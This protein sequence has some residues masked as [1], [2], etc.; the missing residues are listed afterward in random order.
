MAQAAANA[1]KPA[2]ARPREAPAESSRYT[3]LQSSAAPS[4][5]ATQKPRAPSA[6]R[7][8]DGRAKAAILGRPGASSGSRRREAGTPTTAIAAPVASRC[9]P[10]AAPAAAA[11]AP[12]VAPARRP[13]CTR[14]AA[15]HHRAAQ[16]LLDL[17]TMHVHRHVERPWPRP[18]RECQPE[19][20]HIRREAG[21]RERQGHGDH[22]SCGDPPAAAGGGEPARQRLREQRTDGEAEQC[23]PQRAG[24]PD[25]GRPGPLG[26]AAPTRRSPPRR[27]ESVRARRAPPGVTPCRALAISA[28]RASSLSS[29]AS[30]VLV[31]ERDLDVAP[32]RPAGPAPVKFTVLLWRMRPRSLDGVGARR[33]LDQHLHRAADEALRALGRRSAGPSS[34]SRSM[35]SRLTACGTWSA[36]RRRLGAAPRREDERE[37]RVVARPAPRPRASARSPPRSRPGSRR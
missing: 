35:R 26:C 18:P 34:T 9:G 28:T 12:F 13:G 10:G 33:P 6:S 37:R 1:T 29:P 23:Q 31:A 17:G 16:S 7:A 8:R 19:R 14:R 5:R 21:Q 30:V 15:R 32:A 25:R 11:S 4:T 2:P 22:T 27:E 3:A 20:E 24:S 36:Q